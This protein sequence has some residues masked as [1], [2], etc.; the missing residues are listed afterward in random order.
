MKIRVIGG[1]LRNV[2][3]KPLRLVEVKMIFMDFD[4]KPV[5][6]SVEQAYEV[7]YKPLAPGA[8]HRF[9][10]NFENLPRNWNHRIPTVE[11][12]RVAY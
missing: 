8:D 6:E 11:A 5:Q 3:D 2:S 4:G 12:V 10:I 7:N 9:E 1:T